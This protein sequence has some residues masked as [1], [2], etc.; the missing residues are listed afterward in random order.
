VP[1]VESPAVDVTDAM[2]ATLVETGGYTH[3]LFSPSAE[4]RAS[5][6]PVPLPGQAVLLL[7]GGLV[8][9]SGALDD[10]IAMVELRRARFHAMVTAGSSLRVVITPL[11][12]TTTS[13]GK[14]LTVYRWVAVDSEGAEVAEV[15][16]VMLRNNTAQE[17]G[18]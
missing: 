3:P 11:E 15:E 13:S 1:S 18:S 5:G 9:Q 8:E 12:S 6:R 7:M 16:A 4:D 2:I 10:A 17:V 14:L